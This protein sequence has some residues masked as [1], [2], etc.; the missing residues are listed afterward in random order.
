MPLRY[1]LLLFFA[2]VCLACQDRGALLREKRLKELQTKRIEDLQKRI[3]RRY[4]NWRANLR[5]NRDKESAQKLLQKGVE[6]NVRT[7]A[8]LEQVEKNPAIDLTPQENWVQRFIGA[9]WMPKNIPKTSL[10]D[11][12]FYL[13]KLQHLFFEGT[14]D[15]GGFCGVHYGY[16]EV[17][18]KQARIYENESF[19][20]VLLAIDHRSSICA[21]DSLW[22]DNVYVPQDS[23]IKLPNLRAGKQTINIK[24]KA[25]STRTAL[26]TT[27]SFLHTFHVLSRQK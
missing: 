12:K 26:D 16:H 22:V 8:L 18:P 7:Q 23:Q 6:I 20:A 1:Y 10:L 15:D 25:I 24:V 2:C 4:A 13:L 14:N 21:V 11:K 3:Q 17:I 5:N 9:D 27:F 19:E